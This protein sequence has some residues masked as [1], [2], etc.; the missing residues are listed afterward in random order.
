[1]ERY[2]STSRSSPLRAMQALE[3]NLKREQ[4]MFSFFLG[5]LVCVLLMSALVT[6]GSRVVSTLGLYEQSVWAADESAAVTVVRRLG[7]VDTSRYLLEAHAT[8]PRAAV[9]A[10]R[11]PLC[12]ANN[13][14]LSAIEQGLIAACHDASYLLVNNG[15]DA[16][17]MLA[18]MA[19]G[20][21]ARHNFPT[22]SAR[23]I[24]IGSESIYYLREQYLNV[25]LSGGGKARKAKGF[26]A[27]RDVVWMAP[28]VEWELGPHSVLAVSMLKQPA[29]ETLIVTTVEL[30]QF[31]PAFA[32]EDSEGNVALIDASGLVLAGTMPFPQA[33]AL[34]QS[35]QPRA[36][37]EFHLIPAVGWGLRWP[38]RAFEG[39]TIV[40]VVPWSELASVL[41]TELL[42]GIG[43]TA[44]AISIL[45]AAGRFWRNHFIGKTYREAKLALEREVLHHLL[46]YASPV[47]LCVIRREGYQVMVHNDIFRRVLQLDAAKPEL[48]PALTLAFAQKTSEPPA[49]DAGESDIRRF[50]FTLE[51]HGQ[52]VHL[53]VTFTPATLNGD[54]V[55]FCAIADTTKH[56]EAE[57]ALREAK[58][59]SDDVAA[60]KL[61]FFASMSHEIRTPLNSL[62]GNLELVSLG[63]LSEEQRAR[64]WAMKLS[65]SDLLQVVNDVLDFSKIDVGQ[66]ELVPEWASLTSLLTD[67]A[68]AHLPV[69]QRQRLHFYLI[70]DAHLP[71]RARIDALRFTQVLNNVLS[72]ALKFTKSGKI[73]MRASWVE[74]QMVVTVTDSGIGIPEALLPRL[75]QPFVQGDQHRLTQIR[76][77]GLGL[78]ICSR[79][80]AMMGGSIVIDSTLGVGTRV[81]IRVPLAAADVQASPSIRLELG[82]RRF[83]VLAQAPEY[84]AWFTE[85]LGH[86]S[87]TAVYFVRPEDAAL[88]GQHDCLIVTDEFVAEDVD[89]V[90]GSREHVVFAT[91]T[92]PL[93][94][95]L[96]AEGQL[97]VCVYSRVGLE[98]ALAGPGESS[99]QA[100]ADVAPG[101]PAAGSVGVAGVP[102]LQQDPR[103]APVI[104]I[105]EDNEL[106]LALLKDQLRTLG[107]QAV[108]ARDGHEA[109]ELFNESR[110]DAVITDINMPEM[111]GFELLE[112]LRRQAPALPV[113]AIS[114]T[115]QAEAVS[116][117]K[118]LGFTDYLTKPTPLAALGDVVRALRE[119]KAARAGLPHDPHDGQPDPAGRTE[120]GMSADRGEQARGG[121]EGRSEAAAS[122]APDASMP[123]DPMP[124]DIP[125]VAS[126]FREPLLRQLQRD[127]AELPAVRAS[128]ELPKLE[129]WLHRVYGGLVQLGPSV[130]ADLCAEALESSRAGQVWDDDVDALLAAVEERLTALRDTVLRSA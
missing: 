85:L 13:P 25:R 76:G 55:Y 103:T 59:A 43:L 70:V 78:S 83:A 126:E 111:G 128:R 4:R 86:G 125:T 90:W 56:F 119:A 118:A 22:K 124:P 52:E 105:A 130:L 48:P 96:N 74:G 106:N 17:L 104:L 44:L 87:D 115:A 71:G 49:P 36:E 24:R 10:N 88:A 62:T 50:S 51:T 120:A 80:V 81:D 18:D 121:E 107:A 58:Q 129:R 46:V 61:Q 5:I 53:E 100:S 19:S 16:P 2:L 91:Q 112:A 89:K 67:A 82:T 1:M 117:G 92:G 23:D 65:T 33:A 66:L 20:A 93:F 42:L 28:P 95:A 75:F 123:F 31:R 68:L 45:L 41:R 99:S 98:R 29:G 40:A 14:P 109:L 32:R 97:Q 73:V 113:Y 26:G 101:A 37:G 39:A 94:P 77:T 54:A 6:L 60:A 34:Y 27:G 12:T 8:A 69:A 21:L 7:M 15:G 63:E 3:A 114:A 122:G 11:E 79:L 127:F 116:S 110:F 9:P 102:A 64:V 84:V 108:T 47:G 30:A 35:V 72:N 57:N 38:S